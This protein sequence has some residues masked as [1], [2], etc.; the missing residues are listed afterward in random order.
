MA[1]YIYI[2]IDVARSLSEDTESPISDL[3]IQCLLPWSS[4]V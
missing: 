2:F 1:I 3:V 4:Q